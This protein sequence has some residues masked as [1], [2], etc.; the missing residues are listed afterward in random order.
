MKDATAILIDYTGAGTAD[1][2][3]YAA[4]KLVFT[5]QTRLNMTVDR[6]NDVRSM[7]RHEIKSELEYMANTIPS[8]WEFV[9]YDF[10][11]NKVTRAFT[12][13]LVRTRTQSYA[14]QT[15]RVLD[16]GGWTYG[17]GP[18]I[19]ADVVEKSFDNQSFQSVPGTLATKYHSHMERT[20]EV[21]DEL[22]AGG[23]AIEDARGV[24]PTNI[25][26][27]IVVHASLRTLAD[28]FRKRASTRTQG[29][30]RHVINLMKAEVLRVHPWAEL[31]FNSTFDKGAADAEQMIIDFWEA[32]RL[33]DQ[34]KIDMIKKIDVMRS[35][36]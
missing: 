9:T 2:A 22:I 31:F 11:L 8:S 33:S 35:T 29:E 10:V 16:V 24:L 18:T 4:E 3:R 17:T 19:K 34:E 13:Q 6:M 28:T 25:H 20:A 36:A 7:D 21:Y 12:H 15:M 1:P 14:Q 30:Y 23:I 27:N 26:T 5:K 32:G